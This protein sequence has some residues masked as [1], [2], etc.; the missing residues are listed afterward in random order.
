MYVCW[1]NCRHIKCNLI[2]SVFLSL[3]Q[4]TIRFIKSCQNLHF[5]KWI[6]AVWKLQN[7]CLYLIFIRLGSND[8]F[9]NFSIFW[10][11]LIVLMCPDNPDW[12][13]TYPSHTFETKTSQLLD[14]FPMNPHTRLFVGL[15]GLLGLFVCVL[16][17]KR[18]WS[19]STFYVITF[20]PWLFVANSIYIIHTILTK[21]SRLGSYYFLI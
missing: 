15:L 4:L 8:F 11:V 18:Q 19:R 14:N 7:F 6:S 13:K 12:R 17:S 2:E 5:G 21:K 20:K 1:C 9:F 3:I 16:G 10:I